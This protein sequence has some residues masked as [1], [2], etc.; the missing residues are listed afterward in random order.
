[1]NKKNQ[2]KF[3]LAAIFGLFFLALAFYLFK[4][5]NNPQEIKFKK[6]GELIFYQKETNKKLKK[7]NIEIAETQKER[8]QGLMNRK[9]MKES[10]A[11]FFIMPDY[12]QQ[13]FWMKDTYIALD[14]I[15][16]DENLKIVKIQKNNPPLS[17]KPIPSEKKAKYVTE[18]TAGFCDKHKIKEG[19]SVKYFKD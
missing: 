4:E 18:T 2:I 10:Q 17:T 14:L 19:D 12:K 8:T 11:M 16:L 1:M 3:F 13:S 9:K 15:F 7:V 5:S 6:E